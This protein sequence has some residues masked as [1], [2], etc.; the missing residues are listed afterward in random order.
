MAKQSFAERWDLDPARREALQA[1]ITGVATADRM[2]AQLEAMKA[3]FLASGQAIAV[4]IMA[5]LDPSSSYALPLRAIAADIATATNAADGTIRSR[6]NGA[7]ILTTDFPATYAALSEGRIS[8]AHADV[9]VDAGLRLDDERARARYEQVVLD[10]AESLTPGRL[11][12][13]AHAV[14]ERVEPT[15]VVER[16]E[17]ARARRCT[18]VDDLGDG[19]SEFHAVVESVRAHAIQ[20]RLTQMGLTIRRAAR[21]EARRAYGPVVDDLAVEDG[22]PVDE[23]TLAQIRADVFADL[24]LTGHPTAQVSDATGGNALAAIRGSVQIT[25]PAETLTGLGDDAAF[26]AGH[27]PVSPDIARRLAADTPTWA[28]L[29]MDPDTGCLRTVDAYTPTA[30]QRRFLAARDEHC[31]F[32]GC[33]QPIHRCDLDHSH[34]HSEGGQTAVCNLSALCRAHHMLKHHGAWGLEHGRGGVMIW[35][36]PTG[37]RITDRPAP[38]VRFMAELDA[39]DP[40]PPPVEI[41]E[42]APF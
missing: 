18:W 19:M 27:G 15:S 39:T 9:I 5:E 8:R 20:D 12:P 14:A 28:R 21:D 13:V 25:I 38:A 42:T 17:T 36:S 23:R 1:V 29:F 26:L 34:D 33:R 24:A 30:A 32:P 6:M 11:R 7:A 2:I 22:D 3:H 37:R 41:E 16:H 40:D 4:E 31:R 35:T 10:R